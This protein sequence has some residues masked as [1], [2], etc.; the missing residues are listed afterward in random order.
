MEIKAGNCMRGVTSL[1]VTP[2]GTS[3]HLA[4]KQE[5]SEHRPS[6]TLGHIQLSTVTRERIRLTG[7]RVVITKMAS[8][9]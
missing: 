2:G 4:G 1:P 6:E 5:T 3:R 8:H 7:R 9:Q